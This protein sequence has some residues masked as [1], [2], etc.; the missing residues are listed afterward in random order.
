MLSKPRSISLHVKS[1]YKNATRCLIS[2]QIGHQVKPFVSLDVVKASELSATDSLTVADAGT[3]VIIFLM[4]GTADFSDST[5]KHGSLQENDVLWIL[6]GSGVH[7]SLRPTTEDCMMVK[8]RIALSPAL[9]CAPAQTAYINAMLVEQDGPAGVL[10]GQCDNARS[11]LA[12]PALINYLVV[13][14][15]SGQSWIYEPSVN[16]PIAWVAVIHGEVK[17]SDR[18]VTSG[19]V[20]VY[21]RSN[22]AIVFSAQQDSIFLLGTSQEY[23]Y[24]LAVEK[25]P[26]SSV[27]ETVELSQF[28]ASAL[29]CN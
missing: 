11:Q 6:A 20:I 15:T 4:S 24:D 2:S 16:H 10:L 9:E 28:E 8:L 3:A 1:D 5:H 27:I 21:E 13:N 23:M 25:Y 7:Y 12:L 26:T 14:L 19:E 18:L 17:T 29:V 22:R